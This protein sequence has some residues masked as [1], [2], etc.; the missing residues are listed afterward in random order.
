[1]NS[2]SYEQIFYQNLMS[3]VRELKLGKTLVLQQGNDPKNISKSSKQW[4]KKDDSCPGSAYLHPKAILWL[5]LKLA[6]HV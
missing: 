1:M 5:D 2:R 3:S 4:L 6:V